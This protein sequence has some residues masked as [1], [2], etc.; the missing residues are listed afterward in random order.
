LYARYRNKKE[1]ATHRPPKPAP[2]E[3][4]SPRSDLKL[5]VNQMLLKN[6]DQ[7]CKKEVAI[8]TPPEA[9]KMGKDVTP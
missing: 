3:E 1:V 4:S 6:H 9:H 7:I 5:P 8:D 2:R